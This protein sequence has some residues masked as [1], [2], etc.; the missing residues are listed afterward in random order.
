MNRRALGH[1][2]RC[3]GGFTLVEA[4]VT[5]AVLGAMGSV[6]SAIILTATD[7][8]LNAATLAQLHTELSVAMDRAVREI[9]GIPLDSTASDI[10]PDVS[11]VS[12]TSFRWRN[13]NGRL[14]LT[15]S[16]L[17]L[18]PPTG[19]PK[20]LLAD[21]SSFVVATFNE[22]N[23]AL[24]TSLTGAACDPIR[25]V[26]LTITLG[27]SGVSETLRTKVFIRST[28]SGGSS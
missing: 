16:N 22:S 21:V 27:R 3:C 9:R 10:A 20:V 1:P 28:L 26:S 4:T 25:R 11:S 5:I 8:Y 18:K 17:M 7:S 14:Y 19:A 23:S 13:D 15:G 12:A 24:S 6:A 2:R